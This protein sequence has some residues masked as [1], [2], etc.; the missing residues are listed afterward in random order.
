MKEK[1]LFNI[2]LALLLSSV[3]LMVIGVLFIYSSGVSSEGVV[4]SR[5]YVKQIIWCSTGLGLMFA[6][7]YID[8]NRLRD[9]S[10][11]IFVGFML[12]LVITFLFGERVNGAKSWLGI[13]QMGIQPSEFAKL[14]TIIF[15][16]SFLEKNKSGITG[17]PNLV[18]S[19]AILLVPVALILVQPDMG[20]ALVYIPIFFFMLFIAGAKTRHLV[21]LFL[22]GGVI[23]FLGILPSLESEI[24]VN[25]ITAVMLL[26]DRTFF[27][28]LLAAVAVVAVLSGAGFF[29]FKKGYYYWIAYVFL[30]L[31]ISL[32]GS[33]VFRYVLRDYQITRFI[34]FLDPSIDPRG[35]GWNVIQSVTAVGSGG[36]TG[37]GFL[38]G[39]Q[40]H[41]RFL[42]QQSTDFIFSIIAEEWGF[43]GSL[44]VF[45]LFMIIL[46]RGLSITYK[47]KDS[48]AS[49]VGA[50][51]TGMIFFH[52]VVNIGMA[53]G[54]MPITGI[55]LFFL[56]YGG[57][58]LWTAAIG[59]G[60]L[61]NIYGRRFTY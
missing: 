11:Y 40:S 19:L 8:Y 28:Y 9:Y 55:P 51:I 45:A 48:F 42:P 1:S 57:S 10:L 59:L 52:A 39:T 37:K 13:G 58:S 35:A 60:I 24:L 4:F 29:I 61:Q 34:V 6:F 49:L 12:L 5:E 20:T 38:A 33:A 18:L 46:L 56:S 17:L 25:D 31:L 36:L 44:V 21:F 32:A 15:L 54:V 47:A 16:A 3:A 41:Y 14:A 2:D 53:M 22:C 43:L 27:T 23:L 7:S 26:T 30:I 50:G